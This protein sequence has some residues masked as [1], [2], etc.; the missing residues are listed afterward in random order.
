MLI[1]RSDIAI[2]P[3]LEYNFILSMDS[4]YSGGC[5]G[6]YVCKRSR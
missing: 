3:V 6:I 1:F 2:V 4:I 5:Y